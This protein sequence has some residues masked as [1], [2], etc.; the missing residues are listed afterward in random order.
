MTLRV[1][2]FPELREESENGDRVIRIQEVVRHHHL[3]FFRGFRH[4]AVLPLR[5]RRVTIIEAIS[6]EVNCR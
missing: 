3:G 5:C 6:A 4:A 2:R 1:A